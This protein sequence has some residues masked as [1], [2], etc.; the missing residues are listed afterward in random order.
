LKCHGRLT[1]G[2]AADDEV[3]RIVFIRGHRD[4]DLDRPVV[5]GDVGGDFGLGFPP[6]PGVAVNAAIDVHESA[7]GVDGE[8]VIAVG[9][10]LE[11]NFYAVAVPHRFVFTLG[12]SDVEFFVRAFVA[13]DGEVE[14]L[15]GTIPSR[16]HGGT[17]NGLGTGLQLTKSANRP[18]TVPF[19]VLV[20]E[21][22]VDD[23]G[24]LGFPRTYS[25]H[26]GN[27]PALATKQL[28]LSAEGAEEN[29]DEAK[30]L[31]VD[32]VGG[33]SGLGGIEQGQGTVYLRF[34][35]FHGLIIRLAVL[36]EDLHRLTGGTV[37][38]PAVLGQL[39]RRIIG[40]TVP[41]MPGR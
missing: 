3:E 17:E 25:A 41:S 13:A 29:V 7:G 12:A 35:F 26:I 28:R 33:H 2:F 19:P 27:G 8:L 23:D 36:E 40:L 6:E 39:G 24:L 34:V 4:S 18:V 10:G 1:E 11:V 38:K 22:A 31:G 30:T 14:V 37:E 20:I 15:A 5:I 21:L 32:R 9:I 16:H